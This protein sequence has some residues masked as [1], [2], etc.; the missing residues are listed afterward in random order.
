MSECQHDIQVL[1]NCLD[2][3]IPLLGPG[4]PDTVTP[5]KEQV[6]RAM[7]GEIECPE[8]IRLLANCDSEYNKLTILDAHLTVHA[9]RTCEECGG[10]GWLRVITPPGEVDRGDPCP[11][12]QGVKP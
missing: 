4:V 6:E 7:S 2:C 11:R 12:C 3:G 8:C 9:N 1:G 10:S 5:P